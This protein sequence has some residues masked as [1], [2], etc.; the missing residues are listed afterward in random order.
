MLQGVNRD[1]MQF[2]MKASWAFVDGSGRDVY[3]DPV[4]DKGKRSKR[5]MLALILKDGKFNTIRK[6]VFF[7]HADNPQCNLLETVY[8]NG[9][10]LV[11]TTFAEVR[12]RAANGF[13]KAA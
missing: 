6:D 13:S 2:A 5:G 4:T 8:R 9:E 3:K 7:D 11:I 10:M 1:T 12:E